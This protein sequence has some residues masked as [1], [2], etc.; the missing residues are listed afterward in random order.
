[1]A[2][3]VSA[4]A[5]SGFAVAAAGASARGAGAFCENPWEW[6][7]TRPHPN[8]ANAMPAMRRLRAMTANDSAESCDRDQESGN[9][10]QES[11]LGKEPEC[12]NQEAVAG[13]SAVTV[14]I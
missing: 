6:A 4:R 10:N 2:A 12:R 7:T 8:P 3:C 1:M 11:G 13:A 9:G 5:S 14:R